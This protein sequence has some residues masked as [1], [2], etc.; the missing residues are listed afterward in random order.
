MLKA[1][2]IFDWCYPQFPMDLSFYKEGYAFFASCAHERLSWFFSDS[3]EEVNTLKEL[4]TDITVQREGE[5]PFFDEML[6]KK[7]G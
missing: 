4:G 2:D 6:A 1:N 7:M 5:K 3:D